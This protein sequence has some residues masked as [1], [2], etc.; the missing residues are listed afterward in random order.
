MSFSTDPAAI[1]PQ[2]FEN[3]EDENNNDLNMSKSGQKIKDATLRTDEE[4]ML[5]G[6]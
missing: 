4:M 2:N 6:N 3:F 5:Q 1:K